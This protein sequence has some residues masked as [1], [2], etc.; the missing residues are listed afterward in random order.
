MTSTSDILLRLIFEIRP[1]DNSDF[2]VS[3]IKTNIGNSVGKMCRKNEDSSKHACLTRFWESS[4]ISGMFRKS[5]G[6][7]Q[8][9]RLAHFREERPGN[10]TNPRTDQPDAQTDA[11]SAMSSAS[12]LF[13]PP[14]DTTTIR[15]QAD[16][17]NVNNASSASSLTACALTSSSADSIEDEES[18]AVQMIVEQWLTSR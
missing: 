9:I 5:Q 17:S 16:L 1:S 10:D 2:C 18:R 6:S 14:G 12:T 7:L 15:S 4:Q 8:N 11:S 3:H 13:G